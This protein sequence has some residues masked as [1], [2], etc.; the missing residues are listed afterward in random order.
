MCFS[1]HIQCSL[2]EDAGLLCQLFTAYFDIK[3]SDWS[4]E[5][6]ADV[7]VCDS[8]TQTGVYT[9]AC[10]CDSVS[11]CVSV[12]KYDHIY[13]IYLHKTCSLYRGVNISQSYIYEVFGSV[14]HLYPEKHVQNRNYSL[15]DTT[16]HFM[17]I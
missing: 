14:F 12:A 2:Y 3:P 17:K 10:S 15:K 16:N 4:E 9:T 6:L 11:H 8:D 5:H 13:H 7:T 1:V